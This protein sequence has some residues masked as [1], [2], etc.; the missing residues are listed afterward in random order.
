MDDY[1]SFGQ[2]YKH[3]EV[4]EEEQALAEAEGRSCRECYMSFHDNRPNSRKTKKPL[5][6]EVA[7]TSTSDD[8]APPKRDFVVKEWDNK[9]QLLRDTSPLV[10]P[11]SYPLLFLKGEPVYS[12][13]TPQVGEMPWEYTI[14][15]YEGEVLTI[16]KIA[17]QFLINV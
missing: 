10:D 11:L 3:L 4:K 15:Y 9:L 13:N 16:S 2:C 8:G 17:F 14:K 1:N 5:H 12:L 7:A 6:N